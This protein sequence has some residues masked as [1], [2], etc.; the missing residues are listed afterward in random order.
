MTISQG[1]F[2]YAGGPLNNPGI[3]LQASRSFTTN[4]Q[5]STDLAQ[6]LSTDGNK[7]TVG[8]IIRGRLK[9]PKSHLFSIPSS[10][11]QSDILS[12]LILGKPISQASDEGSDSA[13]S[14][15]QLLLSAL[16]KLNLGGGTSG[17]Q[18]TDQLKHAFGIDELNFE[19]QSHYDSETDTVNENTALVIGKSLSSKLSMHY[20]V[21]FSQG[22]SLLKIKYQFSPRWAIQTETSGNTNGVDLIYNY[23]K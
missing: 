12:M 9:S 23:H 4:N 14:S 10:R 1:K 11:S 18:L 19:S 6:G 16:T 13:L 17:Q 5:Y 2:I 20:S 15:S 7:I 21:G 8:L 3:F 22:T